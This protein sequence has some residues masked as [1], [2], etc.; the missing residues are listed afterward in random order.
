MTV[1]VDYQIMGLLQMTIRYRCIGLSGCSS[2]VLPSHLRITL[3]HP[4]QAARASARSTAIRAV[5]C[6][7]STNSFAMLA[8]VNNCDARN[9][10]TPPKQLPHLAPP[11]LTKTHPTTKALAPYRGPGKK[12]RDPSRSPSNTTL[13]SNPTPPSTPSRGSE[14]SQSKQQSMPE[15]IYRGNNEP[16]K[17]PALRVSGGGRGRGACTRQGPCPKVQ[18]LDR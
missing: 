7:V 16:F 13:I 18:R 9:H 12:H 4:R 2:Y 14:Q 8:T 5:P 11:C 3:G 6:L 17:R 1:R 10:T 15:S